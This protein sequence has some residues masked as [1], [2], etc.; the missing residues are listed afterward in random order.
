MADT[1]KIGNQT[2]RLKD[3]HLSKNDAAFLARDIRKSG[4]KARV[5]KEKDE[6]FAKGYSYSIYVK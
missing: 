4:K 2:F 3:A 6:T 1:K 5:I